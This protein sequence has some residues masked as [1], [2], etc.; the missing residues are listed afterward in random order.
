MASVGP[1]NY[2]VVVLPVRGSKAFDIKLALHREPLTGNTWFHDGSI[3]PNEEHVD[4]TI[5]KLL[6]K[7]GLPLTPDYLTML[8]NNLVRVSLLKGKR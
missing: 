6:G 4:A 2:V 8:S 1:G 7:T 3:L 5:R